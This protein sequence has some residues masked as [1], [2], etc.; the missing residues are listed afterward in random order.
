[1]NALD[2][3]AVLP[4]YVPLVISWL[5]NHKAEQSQEIFSEVV[6]NPWQIPASSD[7]LPSWETPA[8]STDDKET[9]SKFSAV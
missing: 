9:G 2:V 6:T 1:M 3:A 7:N 4:F 5:E 8:Y